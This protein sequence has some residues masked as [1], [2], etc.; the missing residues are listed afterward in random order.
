[1]TIFLIGSMG[2]GKSAL[3]RRVT[4]RMGIPFIDTDNLIVNYQG[5]SINDIFQIHGEPY[6]RELETKIL[7]EIDHTKSQIIATGG[8]L[9]LTEDNMPYMKKVGITI[10]LADTLENISFRLH[11][12]KRKRPAIK[13]LNMDEIKDKLDQMLSIRVPV[14]EKAHLTFTRST[15]LEQDADQLGT[16]LRMFT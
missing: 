10:Y 6:F 5:H 8:G 16:Y 3:G 4:E 13:D 1:M 15:D 12:G 11:K 9:P 2:V 14:Y 7:T